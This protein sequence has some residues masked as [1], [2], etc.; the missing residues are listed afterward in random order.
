M[1]L[2]GLASLV[3]GLTQGLSNNLITAN[4]QAAQGH[5][6]A[7]V[8]EAMWLSA[9]Y[10]A[11]NVTATLL[12]YKVR[13]QFGLRRFA[14]IGLCLM[15]VVSFAH[16]LT[17]D[18][19]SAVGLRAVAGFAG[20]PLS[21]LAFLYML[22]H[23]PVQYKLTVGLSFGLLGSQLAVPL[24]RV[25]SPRLLEIGLWHHLDM[26]ELAM[27]LIA[28]ALV[29]LLPLVSPPR[30]KAFDRVDAVSLPLLVIGMALITIVL[31]L[32]RYYWWTEASWLGLCL[33]AGVGMLTI[34]VVIELNRAR[35]VVNLHWLTT[36]D[37]LIFAGSL[38]V[39]RFVLAVQTTGTVGFFQTLGL[40]NDQMMTMFWLTLLA[41]AAGYVSVAFV[42]KPQNAP[43]IHTVAMLMIGLGAWMESHATSLTRPHEVYLPQVLITFGG[44]IFLP[45]AMSWSLAHVLRTG[46]QN[47]LSYIAV[48]LSSMNIGSLLGSA[49]LGSLVTVREKFHS[50][51]IVESLNLTDPMVVQRLQQYGASQARVLGDA[52]LRSGEGT[53]MLGQVATREAYVLAYNDMFRVVAIASVVILFLLFLHVLVTRLRANA[54]RNQAQAA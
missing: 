36:Y 22:E 51:H 1:L 17:S 4:L 43:A 50:N 7:T 25:I 28:L 38:I 42:N 23:L 10:T 44:A 35:P 41:T 20:A 15:V 12:L 5:F 3:L 6:G 16:F 21:T 47:I 49:A 37:I 26:V 53:V 29:Y 2:Y 8:N 9:A 54:A 45:S 27:S 52:A 48:F 31:S 33:A 30:V 19:H 18:L 24:A 46:P 34:F 13:S 14:E 39:A 32:G 11:T 40:Q